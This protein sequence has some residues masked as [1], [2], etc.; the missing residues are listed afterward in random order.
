MCSAS[1]AFYVLWCLD[2]CRIVEQCD[3]D[4]VRHIEHSFFLF[5]EIRDHFIVSS[6]CSS[7]FPSMR[8]RLV[9]GSDLTF[10][11]NFLLA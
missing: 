3:R 2:Y 10:H 8:G 5:R 11:L 1:N 7:T 9:T 6:V 4:V